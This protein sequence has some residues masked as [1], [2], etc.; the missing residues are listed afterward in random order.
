[1]KVFGCSFAKT[2]WEFPTEK[3][4][5]LLVPAAEAKWKVSWLSFPRTIGHENTIS[6][7]ISMGYYFSVDQI[8]L[9]TKKLFTITHLLFFCYLQFFRVYS[10]TYLPV[11]FS[12]TSLTWVCSFLGYRTK[13]TTKL[14]NSSNLIKLRFAEWWL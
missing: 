4:T 8:T 1:M 13:K 10:T 2:T 7:K 11:T 5:K 12:K 6:D 3:K 14:N 9:E